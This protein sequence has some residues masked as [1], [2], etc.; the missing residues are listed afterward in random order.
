MLSIQREMKI[1][2][3][4][5]YLY[6]GHINTKLRGM[7]LDERVGKKLSSISFQGEIIILVYQ[8]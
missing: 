6:L 4:N 7:R 3:V 5:Q 1:P 8:K 2:F